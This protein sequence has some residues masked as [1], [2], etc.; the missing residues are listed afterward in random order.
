MAK[1]LWEIPAVQSLATTAPK[2]DAPAQ[3]T[4]SAPATSTATPNAVTSTEILVV[5]P[6]VAFAQASQPLLTNTPPLSG[7]H[8]DSE[9]V[10]QSHTHS[11][12]SSDS[13]PRKRARIEPGSESRGSNVAIEAVDAEVII[14]EG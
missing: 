13:P 12:P 3:N 1:N 8:L 14:S 9:A 4:S 5:V 6:S 2:T 10:R 11:L 7:V